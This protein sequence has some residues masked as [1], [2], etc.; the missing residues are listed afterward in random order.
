MAARVGPVH[1]AVGPMLA[2]VLVLGA[3]GGDGGD[4]DSSAPEA[5]P[6]PSHAAATGAIPTDL[7]MDSFA[8]ITRVQA[9]PGF[10]GAEG[11]TDTSIIELYPPLARSVLDA[12]Y[13]ILSGDNEGFEA[14]IFFARGR[15]T[16][17]TYLMREG[18]CEGQVTLKLIYSSE[19]SDTK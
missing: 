8:T 19:G 15:R 17:G 11:V 16:T 1:L 18:P 12:G 6:S 2:A 4:A 9:K 5:C 3:C 14:E 7:D 13:D 10:V